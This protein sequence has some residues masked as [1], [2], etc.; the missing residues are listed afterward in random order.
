MDYLIEYEGIFGVVLFTG[1]FAY[2]IHKI[3]TKPKIKRGK[4]EKIHDP[5]LLQLMRDDTSNQIV[6]I[7]N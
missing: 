4:E 5:Y 7:I 1:L 2:G 6:K 3:I